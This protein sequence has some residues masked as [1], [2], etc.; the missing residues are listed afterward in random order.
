M[1]CVWVYVFVVFFCAA[2]GVAIG[3]SSAIFLSALVCAVLVAIFS[4]HVLVHF[5]LFVCHAM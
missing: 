2:F 1:L 5:P 3:S 4:P